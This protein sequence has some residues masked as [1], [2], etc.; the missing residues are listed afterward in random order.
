MK[1][2]GLAL[3]LVA[4]VWIGIASFQGMVAGYNFSKDI[5]SYWS[6]A[7]KASTISQKSEYMD[8]FVVALEN[9]GLKGQND[10]LLFPTID[11]SFD[12]N[13]D[14][15]KSLQKRLDDIK[16]MDISS[17]QYQTAIEQITKQEQGEAHKMLDI[18]EGCWWKVHQGNLW[19]I[20]GFL[21]FLVPVIIGIVGL[22]I[23]MSDF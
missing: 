16:T 5:G 9:S 20:W 7:E 23:L 2:T 17:F 13:L 19:N 14:A 10:T 6:L 18:L 12:S 21:T 15:L 11:N 4:L 22:A 1:L 3:I 8:K